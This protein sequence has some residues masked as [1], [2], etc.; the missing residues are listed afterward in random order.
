[1]GRIHKKL[2][3]HRFK[4]GSIP[5]NKGL[6]LDEVNSQTESDI[7]SPKTVR[8]TADMFDLVT[9]EMNHKVCSPTLAGPH[10]ARLLRPK[11]SV[12]SEKQNCSVEEHLPE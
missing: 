12:R 4:K 9:K 5:Y 10:S 6:K 2:M 1:M 8:L 3:S 7:Q 11:S